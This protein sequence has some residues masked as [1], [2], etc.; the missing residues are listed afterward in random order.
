M[1]EYRAQLVKIVDGD[2]VKL[3]VDLGFRIWRHAENYRLARIN[4]P[5][6]GQPGGSEA[7]AAL[8]ALLAPFPSFTVVSFKDDKYGRYLIEIVLP[9]GTNVSDWLLGNGFA[10]E[11]GK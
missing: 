1:Y 6:R 5:E 11:Y 9:D 7:T 8:S 10:E 3:D 2:T 4:T